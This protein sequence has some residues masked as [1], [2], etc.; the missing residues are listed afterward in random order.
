VTNDAE[1]PRT[2]R[3]AEGFDSRLAESGPLGFV[4]FYGGRGWFAGGLLLYTQT[5]SSGAGR[6]NVEGL[7][8][9]MISTLN[10]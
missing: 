7:N 3:A 10:V 9:E 6:V 2:P 1:E 8:V 4:G 5:S